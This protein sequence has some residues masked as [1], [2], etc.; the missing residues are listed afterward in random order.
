M[1]TEPVVRP[2]I[3]APIV[4]VIFLPNRKKAEKHFPPLG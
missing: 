3:H 4:L 2:A 1:K